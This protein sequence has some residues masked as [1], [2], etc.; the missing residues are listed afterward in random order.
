MMLCAL[1]WKILMHPQTFNA[2]LRDGYL[3]FFVRRNLSVL[4]SI[5]TDT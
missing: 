1:G 5:L 4:L 2:L 3:Y